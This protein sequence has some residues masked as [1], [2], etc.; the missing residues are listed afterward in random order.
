LDEDTYIPVKLKNSDPN[1]EPVTTISTTPTISNSGYVIVGSYSTIEN[2]QKQ[3][4][5]LAS[6][7]FTAEILQ[8]DGKIRVTAGKGNQFGTLKAR[9]AEKGLDCWLLD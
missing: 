5:H 3:V 2:A 6:L 8:R 9:L 4:D 7:G 1:I